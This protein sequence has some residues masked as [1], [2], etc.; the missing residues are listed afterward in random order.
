MLKI[1][2]PHAGFTTNSVSYDVNK[3]FAMNSFF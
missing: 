2:D 1:N 3:L